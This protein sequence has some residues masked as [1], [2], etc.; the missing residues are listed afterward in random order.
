MGNKN[1]GLFF[2]TLCA[3]HLWYIQGFTV[4]LRWKLMSEFWFLVDLFLLIL[5]FQPHSSVTVKK[6]FSECAE[7]EIVSSTYT[8]NLPDIIS[9]GQV[10]F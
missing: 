1:L 3:C 5:P 2:A 7:A 4:A 10:S 6:E 8:V 9:N